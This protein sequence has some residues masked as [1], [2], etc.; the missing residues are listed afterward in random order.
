MMFF[1]DQKRLH[2]KAFP[3]VLRQVSRAT[4]SEKNGSGIPTRNNI[5]R[6]REMEMTKKIT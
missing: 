2:E 6:Y 3:T 4:G 5:I 1:Q